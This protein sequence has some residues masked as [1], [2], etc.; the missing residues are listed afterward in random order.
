M[1][2]MQPTDKRRPQRRGTVR[3]SVRVTQQARGKAK[4]SRQQTRV[5]EKHSGEGGGRIGDDGCDDASGSV[6]G[7]DGSPPRKGDTPVSYVLFYVGRQSTLIGV[8]A[9]RHGQG[10]LPGSYGITVSCDIKTSA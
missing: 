5:S 4:K 2:L 7:K 1:F 6:R 10:R 8:Q 9:K 3:R